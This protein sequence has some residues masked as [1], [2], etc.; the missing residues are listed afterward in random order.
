M[1]GVLDEAL[2]NVGAKVH[3]QGHVFR[4]AAVGLFG[5]RQTQRNRVDAL[6][7]FKKLEAREASKRE[8]SKRVGAKERGQQDG[9]ET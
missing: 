1:V 8:A 2:E 9:R 7:P 5:V 3:H 6:V 4:V